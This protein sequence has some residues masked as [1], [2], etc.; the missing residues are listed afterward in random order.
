MIHKMLSRKEA[1]L[2]GKWA[3]IACLG[4]MGNKMKRI[5]VG[6][7]YN[8]AEKKSN[9]NVLLIGGTENTDLNDHIAFDYW[10]KNLALDLTD[11]GQAKVDFY[12]YSKESLETNIHVYWDMG[13]IAAI[14]EDDEII[15]KMGDE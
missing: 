11:A 3:R 2:I 9:V 4:A 15:W 10:W 5:E 6:V 14:T 8:A 13:V 12:I 1:D 7:R